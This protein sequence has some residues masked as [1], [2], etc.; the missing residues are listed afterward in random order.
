MTRLLRHFTTVPRSQEVETWLAAQQAPLGDIAWR[1]FQVMRET[2]R[3][4]REVM[5][6]GHA[7]ACVADAPFAYVAVF[8]A[9]VNVGF[10]RGFALSDPAGLLTGTGKFMRHVRVGPT[11]SVDSEA[12]TVL[13]HAAYEDVKACL[14]C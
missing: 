2:N 5:H 9:H 7:A 8:T 10:Y 4:V 13:I 3:D 1:W 12:L 14:D 11:D 6:D